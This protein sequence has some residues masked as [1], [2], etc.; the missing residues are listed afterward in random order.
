MVAPLV[1][2]ITPL[3]HNKPEYTRRCAKSVLKQTFENFEWICI[4]DDFKN[5][6]EHDILSRCALAERRIKLILRSGKTTCADARNIGIAKSKGE[7]ICFLDGD[8]T[9]DK[10]KISDQITFMKIRPALL[11]TCT[12]FQTR[13]TGTICKFNG[14]PTM[15][16]TRVLVNLLGKEVFRRDMARND[17][18]DLVCR[19]EKYPHAMIEKPLT[20][21]Q[22]SK[23][24]LTN[25]TS[26]IT[27]ELE[28]IRIAAQNL[29]PKYVFYHMWIIFSRTILTPIVNLKK[30]ALS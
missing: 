23:D 29:R 15:M 12:Y 13:D 14:A 20:V 25:S 26:L 18:F 11:W 2:I 27:S 30:E 7:Y 19:I 4:I 16:I 8:D 21:W 6:S 28:Y 9:F 5:G 3:Y 1:S 24:G 10:D 17:D 22:S